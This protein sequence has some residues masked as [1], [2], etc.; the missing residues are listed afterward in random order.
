MSI[1]RRLATRVWSIHTVESTAIGKN[2][3]QLNALQGPD[4]KMEKAKYKTV[5][6]Y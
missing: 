3:M 2:E 4:S 1:G 6:L 5:L